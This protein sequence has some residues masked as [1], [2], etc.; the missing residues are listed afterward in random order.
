MFNINPALMTATAGQKKAYYKKVM[1]LLGRANIVQ[2]IPGFTSGNDIGIY[3]RTATIVGTP[4]AGTSTNKKVSFTTDGIDDEINLYSAGYASG[5]SFSEGSITFVAKYDP[6][7]Y[8]DSANSVIFTFRVNA[9]NYIELVNNTSG[10]FIWYYRGGGTTKSISYPYAP[11]SNIVVTFTWS[12]SNDR[13][14]LFINGIQAYP[15]LTSLPTISGSLSST[16]CMFGYGG[17][18]GWTKLLNLSDI[19]TTNNEIL[20]ATAL[21]LSKLLNPSIKTISIIGDSLEDEW[22]D[23][24]QRLNYKNGEYRTIVH[25]ISGK[26]IMD[27]VG[28]MDSQVAASM[29]DNADLAIFALGT[30]DNNGGDMTALKAKIVSGVTTY[31]GYNPRATV[32]YMNILKRWTDVGGGTEV[33]KSNL[34]TAISQA[35]ATLGITVLNPYTDFSMT[36]SDT[37]DGTHFTAAGAIKYGSTFITPA[38]P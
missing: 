3:G 11:T 33:D 2:Y 6:A 7:I 17:D 24:P 16:Y 27:A 5:F 29:T 36:V 32:F 35:G 26:S 28:G 21:A 38:L 12:K 14:R 31:K 10:D 19:I 23:W 8:S 13:V 1:D 20:P 25:A 37:S 9:S 4:V 34:R 15:D 18:W 22:F 30:N